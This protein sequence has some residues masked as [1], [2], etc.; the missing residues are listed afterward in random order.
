MHTRRD[1]L[2]TISAPP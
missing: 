1:K 2:I